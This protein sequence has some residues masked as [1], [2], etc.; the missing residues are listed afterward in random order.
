[1]IK[2]TPNPPPTVLFTLIDN[3]SSEDLLVNL[4]ETLASAH[5]LTCDFAFDLEGTQREGALG[6]AQLI[7]VGRLLAER[8]L[9][10]RE[11]SREAQPGKL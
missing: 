6:I 1:M 2:P 8:L 4:T 5:A 9:D 3:I 7:E 10:D 11:P